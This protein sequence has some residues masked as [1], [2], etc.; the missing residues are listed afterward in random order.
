MALAPWAMHTRPPQNW[1]LTGSH[2]SKATAKMAGRWDYLN[3]KKSLFCC[4]WESHSWLFWSTD[5]VHA[6]S[7]CLTDSHFQ[8]A[9]PSCICCQTF[10]Q[11]DSSFASPVSNLGHFRFT[12]L[13]RFSPRTLSFLISRESKRES[14]KKRVG[15]LTVSTSVVLMCVSTCIDV[16]TSNR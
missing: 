10:P 2:V 1:W 3:P 4:D 11:L 12:Y 6:W 5:L 15:G 13:F 9:I 14:G 8:F 7:L 16:R